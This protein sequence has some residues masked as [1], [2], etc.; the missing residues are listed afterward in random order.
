MIFQL[1]K[2]VITTSLVL[3]FY[4]PLIKNTVSVGSILL[5]SKEQKDPREERLGGGDRAS[6]WTDSEISIYPDK[7]AAQ[8]G[9]HRLK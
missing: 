8:Q 3:T 9:F 5:F 1:F 7:E 6:A 2:W 4:L